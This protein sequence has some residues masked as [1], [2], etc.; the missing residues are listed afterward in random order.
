MIGNDKLAIAFEDTTPNVSRL[1]NNSS[2]FLGQSDL[3]SFKSKL[4]TEPTEEHPSRISLDPTS[5][6]LATDDL[7]R[8]PLDRPVDSTRSIKPENHYWCTVCEEPNSY[9][10]SG[11]WKKHEKAH[12][13]IFVCGLEEATESRKAGQSHASKPFTCKRRDIM[14]NHLNRM[15]GVLETQRGR[16]LADQWRHTVKKQAW[17]CGFCIALFST[18]QDRLKHIDTE[19]FRRHQSI[20]EWDPNKVILGLLQQPKMEKTWKTRTAS[21]PHWVHSEDL[22]W[23]KATARDLRTILEIGPSDDHHAKT[24][25]DAAYSARQSNERPW[26]Q[27]GTTHANRHSNATAQASFLSSPIPY[28]ATSTLT[29]GSGLYHQPRPPITGPTTHLVSGDCSYSRYPTHN[30]AFGNT[31]EPAMPSSGDNGRVDHNALRF[32]PSQSWLAASEPSTLP[33]GLEPSRSYAGRGA[34]FSTLNWFG[35]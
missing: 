35:Q 10:D 5:R 11:N 33:N 32:S 7:S 12:E 28:Q 29:S 21:L 2:T 18:F 14:V 15:H 4:C 30:F 19:H 6:S 23:D 22:A 13:T 34:D 26:P 25:A 27:S 8:Y 20:H 16:D 31:M 3:S 1:S 9:K 24:L 17:S